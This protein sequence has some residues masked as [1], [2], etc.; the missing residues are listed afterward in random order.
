[1]RGILLVL[2]VIFMCRFSLAQE[3]VFHRSDAGTNNWWD[4]NL[5]WFYQTSNN[6]QNRPDNSNRHNVFIEHN[7]NT[8]M[9]INGAFFTLRSLNL[10]GGATTSRTFGGNNTN[11]GIGFT[12]GIFNNSAATH[13]FNA[14][15]AADANIILNAAGGVLI[16][17]REIFTNGN[18]ITLR[19]PQNIDITDIVSQTGSIVKELGGI[20]TLSGACTYTG[21]TTINGGTVRLNRT[22]GSTLSASNDI[23]INNGGTLQVSTNQTIDLLTVNAGGTL[24]VDPGTTLTITGAFTGGGTI[25]NNG[26]IVL[27]GSTTQ[28]F[29]GTGATVSAMNE[30]EI[31]NAAG[32]VVN[33]SFTITRE[34]ALTNGV[35]TTTSVNLLTMSNGSFVTGGS[36]SSF[37]NGPIQK[38]GNTAFTFPV[39]KVVGGT[40]HYRTIGMSAPGNAT[41]AFTA[42]FFRSSSNSR[43]TISTVASANGLQRVSACEHWGLVRNAGTTNVSVTL[44][45]EAASR[46]N[47]GAYITDLSK[48]VVVQYNSSLQWGDLYGNTST[49]GSTTAGT[50]TWTGANNF[51]YFTLGSTDANFNPLPF[52]LLKFEGRSITNAIELNFEITDNNDQLSYT[53]ERSRN[54]LN[55]ESLKTISARENE[56]MTS[57]TILD[58]QPFNGWNYYRLTGNGRNGVKR[59]SQI[60]RVWYG[61][62]KGN[63]NVYPNPLTNNTINLFT[64]GIAKG[65]YNLHL[66]SMDRKIVSSR[67]WVFDGQSLIFQWNVAVPV[68]QG[69]YWLV[70]TGASNETWRIKLVR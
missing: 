48:L 13:T 68:P 7:N 43:G 20:A 11:E 17:N 49:A 69:V 15:I 34:L 42:E 3:N 40:N 70:L 4:S 53:I 1:M 21:T 51:V 14:R 36:S 54:A 60:I 32:V 22:G 6:N 56:L 33:N 23:V 31:N 46:C 5:P 8:A 47:V 50:I 57:Y 39:G 29:P 10:G 18:T 45:W 24:Q 30:L 61:E 35:L 12:S 64:G 37:V 19:G 28:N 58:Q 59:Q 67:Q 27:A 25:I 55:F 44:S 66:V 2:G 26:R 16:F 65:T 52:N 63:P 9:N 62:R 38:V 41:D